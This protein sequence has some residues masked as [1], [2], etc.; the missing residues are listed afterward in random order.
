MSRQVC[1]KNSVKRSFLPDTIY[2][3]S[4]KRGLHGPTYDVLTRAVDRFRRVVLG[5]ALGR[6]GVKQDRV[7]REIRPLFPRALRTCWRPP[8]K[9]SCG[10]L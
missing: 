9:R 1:R 7:R 5:G 2:R 3:L 10:R 6:D 8:K 4:C